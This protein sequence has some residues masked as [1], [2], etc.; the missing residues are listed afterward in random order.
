[1]PGADISAAF[2]RAP[3]FDGMATIAADLMNVLY[4]GFDNPITISIPDV[5]TVV[6]TP[7]KLPEIKPNV[8]NPPA[9]DEV[10]IGFSQDM[11]GAQFYSTAVE[12]PGL[13]VPFH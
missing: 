8:F 5:E 6:F 13:Q 2:E 10:S 12:C 4:A 9:L 3:P 11:V 1:M 7:T